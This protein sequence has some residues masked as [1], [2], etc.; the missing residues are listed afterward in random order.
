[1]DKKASDGRTAVER[2]SERELVV[3]RSFNAPVRLVFDAWTKPELFKQWWAPK[4]SGVPLLACEMDARTGGGYSVTFGQ[5][6]SSSMT[7][8]GKYLEVSPPSRLVWTNDESEN[9]SVTTVTFEEQDGR[10]LLVLHELYPSKEACDESCAGMEGAMPEQFG[11]LD[12]LL[13]T[14]GASA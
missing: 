11:Q 4:S 5:D 13:V 14:L 8:F 1:M 9:G 2:R 12:E 7:F 6:A 3:T 10:T